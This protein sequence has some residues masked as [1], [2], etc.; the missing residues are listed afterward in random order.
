M[1]QQYAMTLGRPL[2]I[3]SIG[4]CPSPEPLLP[5]PIMQSLSNGT[6]R[7]TLLGRQILSAG[8]L[9]NNQV[10]NYT[11]QL[12]LLKRTLPDAI[13]FDETWLNPEKNLPAWPFDLQAGMLHANIHNCLILLNQKRM[14]N[15]GSTSADLP[16]E[17]S[18]APSA[19]NNEFS[20]RGRARVLDSCRALLIA[21]EFFQTRVPAAM[22]YW[23]IGQMAFNAAMILM[24]SMLETREDRDLGAIQHTYTT[25]ID[26]NKLGIHKLAG[27]A[28]ERLGSL[29]K[30][31]HSEETIKEKV[32]G[33]QGMIL[34]E[35]PG[36]QTLSSDGFSPLNFHMADGAISYDR[37][38]KRRNTIGGEL[39]V[40]AK[41][42]SVQKRRSH[43]H[44]YSGRD[45]R[46]RIPSK[47]L[48][49]GNLRSPI[50]HPPSGG[51]LSPKRPKKEPTT[52][53]PT[54]KFSTLPME[55]TSYTFVSPTQSEPAVTQPF[56][57]PTEHTFQS[58]QSAEFDH[59]ASSSQN[60]AFDPIQHSQSNNFPQQSRQHQFI[61]QNT[62]TDTNIQPLAYNPQMISSNS[63]DESNF[64]STQEQQQQL[65]NFNLETQDYLPN[66]QYGNAQYDLAQIPVSYPTQF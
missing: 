17:L 3:S 16:N 61:P 33:Q 32:M 46:P 56:F 24:L 1:D 30:D 18:S 44:P 15:P 66:S 60:H 53:D 42:A 6:S 25:F 35:N 62:S 22:I 58:F 9:N 11:D 40:P 57:S 27:A 29:M 20:P 39:N 45:V 26:M 19:T 64:Q 2:A 52:G 14:E 59:P 54:S 12:L 31:L 51:R 7:F 34:L 41:S 38:H 48:A 43:R 13:R 55:N 28:V 5:D 37:P 10:D 50:H 23:S 21:F 47:K 8:C 65:M 4:D 49:L 36:F 63:I